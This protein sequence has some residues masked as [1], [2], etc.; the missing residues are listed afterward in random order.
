[1]T[2]E[3]FIKQ[4]EKTMWFSE[5]D[6]PWVRD[7]LFS[8]PKMKDSEGYVYAYYK[9]SDVYLIRDRKRLAIKIGLTKYQPSRRINHTAKTNGERYTT[10]LFEFTKYHKYLEFILHRY[11]KHAR[12]K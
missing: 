11:F 7:E 6:Y 10:L 2:Y 4:N 3:E 12:I 1:M 9:S 8:H 5:A